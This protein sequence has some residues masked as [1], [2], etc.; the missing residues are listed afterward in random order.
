M[1][2]LV[3]DDDLSTREI[4]RSQL[5]MRGHSVTQALDGADAL[6]RLAADP[7]ISVLITD[8]LMP[9]TD[10]PTLCREARRMQR[11]RYL[12][13]IMLT[14]N[15]QKTDLIEGLNAG[16][17]AFISKPIDF[18][19]IE[20][21]LRTATR[22]LDLEQQLAKRVTELEQVHERVQKDLAAA[23]AVQRSLLPDRGAKFAGLQMAWVY[24]ACTEVAGDMFNV[25]RLDEESVGVYILDVCGHGV[26]AALLSVTLSRI[27]TPHPQ[28]GGILKRLAAG[29]HHYELVAPATIA[30]ELNRRFPVLGDP[31]HYFTFLYGVLNVPARVFRYVRAGHPGPVWIHDGQATAHNEPGGV[32]IGLGAETAYSEGILDLSHGD[33]L[34][35]HTDGLNE[36]ANANGE[37]FGMERVTTTLAACAHLGV[38]AAVGGLMTALRA[39]CGETRPQDDV[40]VVGLELL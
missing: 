29:G 25:Q 33:I 31:G 21:H 7:D 19:E 35:F 23:A 9:R 38:D 20:A 15:T 32:A 30:E 36:A 8:W 27:L 26:P 6:Q 5:A 34:V 11:P 3:C 13:I 14:S 39:F 2:I 37:R 24:E 4:L 10:G 16:A 12:F 28:Q 22:I 18:A 17:D 40:T 1:R